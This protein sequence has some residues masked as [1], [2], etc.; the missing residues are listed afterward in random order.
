MFCQSLKWVFI[1]YAV[2]LLASLVSSPLAMSTTA[3]RKRPKSNSFDLEP[4]AKKP[5]LQN[6]SA[7]AETAPSEVP[8]PAESQ[9]SSDLYL[10]TVNRQMLDFD[11]E[12]LCSVSLSNLNVYACLVCG[13]YFQGWCFWTVWIWPLVMYWLDVVRP[14]QVLARVFPQLTW[15][16]PCFYQPANTERMFWKVSTSSHGCNADWFTCRSMSFQ[17][18]TRWSTAL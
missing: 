11:F 10:D 8:N 1:R 13:K 3:E 18:D 2:T 15:R 4:T 5:R 16:P 12:K 17:T 7:D 14:R 6:E 9:A